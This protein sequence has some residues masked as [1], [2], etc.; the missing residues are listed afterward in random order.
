MLVC[1]MKKVGLNYVKPL[2]IEA[3]LKITYQSAEYLEKYMI[4]I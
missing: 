4:D 3:I 2:L 1:S